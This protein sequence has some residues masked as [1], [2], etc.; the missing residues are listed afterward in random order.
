[1]PNA[2]VDNGGRNMGKEEKEATQFE[3]VACGG[4][5]SRTRVAKQN[6]A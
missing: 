4:V 3:F 2:A 1:M 5:M 6:T